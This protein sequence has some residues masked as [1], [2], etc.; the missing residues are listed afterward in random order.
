MR[1]RKMSADGDYLFGQGSGFLVNSPETVAQAVRTRLKLYA[2][3]WF[4]DK[5]EGLDLDQVT[6]RGTQGTRDQQI[7]Q[8]ILRTSGVRRLLAYSSS[9]E[10]RAFLVSATIETI[11]GAVTI[12]ETL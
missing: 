2:R 7:Q 11:Y 4:L 3:E 10:G 12:S 5:R 1:Y 6:G 8:R 9:I